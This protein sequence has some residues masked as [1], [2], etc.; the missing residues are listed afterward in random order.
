MR[1]LLLICSVVAAVFATNCF[2]NNYPPKNQTMNFSEFQIPTV[3]QTVNL[4][5]LYY[6]FGHTNNYLPID[7]SIDTLGCNVNELYIAGY[8]S[9]KGVYFAIGEVHFSSG[10]NVKIDNIVNYGSHGNLKISS[11]DGNSLIISGENL[12]K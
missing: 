8:D 12:S 10:E 7:R 5:G 1:K 6:S 3:N 11:S 9:Q 2:A 4:P